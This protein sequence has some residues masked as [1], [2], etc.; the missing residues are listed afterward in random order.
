M[1]ALL[2]KI[3]KSRKIT[4]STL[5]LYRSNLNLAFKHFQ[6]GKEDFNTEFLSDHEGIKKFLESKKP[7]TKRTYY[8]SFSAAA[9]ALEK[10]DDAKF[11]KEQIGI[12][13]TE[14][15]KTQSNGE[16]TESQEKNWMPWKKL[17]SVF[18]ALERDVKED[19]TALNIKKYLISGL[20]VADD[21]NP[22]VR[23]DYAGMKIF[24]KAEFEKLD[25]KSKH[26]YLVLDG[27]KKFFSFNN[28]KTAGKRGEQ[29]IDV[30]LKLN[31]VLNKY[32]A[33]ENYGDREYLIYDGH[34]NYPMTQQNLGIKITQV[35]KPTK[36]HVTVNLLRH[37]YISEKFPREVR[38][39]RLQVADKMMHS[40]AMQEDLYAKK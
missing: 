1:D 7:N 11:F 14:I 25:D 27:K 34:E 35:F 9:N 16:K 20:Y 40:K 30:G 19:A 17:K 5:L 31:K 22:P 21:E 33:F 32:L 13:K 6:K 10:K 4:E 15:D 23:L 29:I 8:S 38:D 18:N 37:I 39:E 28:Y 24:S 26:N 2:E 12:L 3:E 36:K